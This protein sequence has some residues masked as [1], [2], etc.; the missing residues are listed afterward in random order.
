MKP[1]EPENEFAGNDKQCPFYCATMDKGEYFSDQ[2]IKDYLSRFLE[3]L[4][5]GDA[6]YQQAI[7]GKNRIARYNEK[8]VC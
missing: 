1:T 2:Q 6:E 7:E 8:N 3:I 5:I 4:D